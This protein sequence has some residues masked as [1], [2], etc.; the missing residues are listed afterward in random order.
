MAKRGRK[1]SVYAELSI[2]AAIAAGVEPATPQACAE[3]PDAARIRAG[4]WAEMDNRLR[5]PQTY[6]IDQVV[7]WAA[8]ELKADISRSAVDRARTRA[9]AQDRAIQ[10]RADLA[11]RMADTM[12]DRGELDALK[13]SRTIAAQLIFEALQGMDPRSLDGMEPNQVLRLISTL[14]YLSKAG[15]ETELA[16]QKLAE[17]QAAFD[18]QV[19]ARTTK[20][21]DGHLTP[22]DIADIRQ[23]VFGRVA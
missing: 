14:G 4:Y 11:R 6:T 12:G 16:K 9:L 10:A 8:A 21:G 20:S 3:D 22:T 17:M 2:A 15:A 19:A 23:A 5:D 1:S 18:A 13:A 7:E